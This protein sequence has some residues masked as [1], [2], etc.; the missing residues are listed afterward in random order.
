MKKLF[1]MLLISLLIITGCS[2]SNSANE[3]KEDIRVVSLAPNI[4]ENI[5]GLGKE[6]L[7]VG[8]DTFSIFD[9]TESLTMFDAMNLNSEEVLSVKPTH[10]F[11][12]EYSTGD[13][14]DPK[15]DIF[16]ES[17]IKV[18]GISNANSIE[19]IYDNILDIS[20]NLNDKESGEKLVADMK[21]K[22]AEVTEKYQDYNTKTVYFE[23]AP[24]PNIYT[25]GGN[26]FLNDMITLAN[27]ENI[28]KDE[29]G[30]ISP[31]SEAVIERNPDVIITNV[32]YI[33]D[34]VGDILNREGF[35]EIDAVQ[36]NHVHKMETPN[37]TSRASYLVVEGIEEIA[38]YIHD[39]E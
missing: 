21:E 25:T 27:G 22:I 16:R 19:E 31:S 9:E 4:T 15:Y 26:S 11:I 8:V 32:S 10:I 39:E 34:P 12:Y 35:N 23:I 13:A 2:N 6:D 30:W 20:T 36:N 14:N 28:F 37:V 1:T 29:T 33:D 5:I 24:S 38:K 3:T 17:D 7:L 18:I